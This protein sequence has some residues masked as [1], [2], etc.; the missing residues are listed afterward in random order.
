MAASA[1][2]DFEELISRQF[3][4]GTKVEISSND[5]GFRG[6]FFSG[7]VIRDL[8]KSRNKNTTS[9]KVLVEYDTIF[10]DNSGSSPLSEEIS[11]VQL[12]P[13]P[14]QD[15]TRPFN[16]SDEVDA[17]YNEGWWEGVITEVLEG[18]R[19]FVFFRGT[20]EQLEFQAKDL[21]LHR[22][23]VR[24][25]WEPPAQPHGRNIQETQQQEVIIEKPNKIPTDYKY[26]PG[27]L[28]EVSSDEDGFQGAWFAAKIVEQLDNGNYL[29]EYKYLRNDE[30]TDFA[31]EEADSQ[32]IRPPPPHIAVDRFEVHQAVDALHKDGWWVG[33]VSRVLSIR[34]Y[35]VYFNVT[36]EKLEFKHSDLRPHQDWIDDKWVIPPKAVKF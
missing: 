36:K 7:T 2:K 4:I 29:V 9:Y 25:I 14:P 21:R 5:E 19:Y 26:S 3:K 33:V 20:R 8:K 18:Q 22:E 34:K 23:W 15:I 28:I 27:E 11:V 12:R 30:N 32:H 13:I 31:R 35:V 1:L 6:S 24:G 10:R 17:Y 16:I